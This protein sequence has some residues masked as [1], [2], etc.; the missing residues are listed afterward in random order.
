MM[1]VVIFTT[2]SGNFRDNFI[3]K[4]FRYHFIQLDFATEQSMR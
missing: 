3:S 1:V 2:S 4:F